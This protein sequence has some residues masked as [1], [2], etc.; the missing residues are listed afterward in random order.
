MAID[1]KP[2]LESWRKE[3]TPEACAPKVLY[4]SGA[5]LYEELLAGGSVLSRILGKADAGEAT[6]TRI[7]EY[8]EENDCF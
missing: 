6:V 3:A 8:F 5:L 2:V 1:P 4:R 7:R